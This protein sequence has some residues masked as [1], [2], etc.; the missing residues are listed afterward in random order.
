VLIII[1]INLLKYGV[2]LKKLLQLQSSNNVDT[3]SKVDTVCGYSQ[4]RSVVTINYGQKKK[5]K[6]KTRCV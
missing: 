4:G 6:Q 1:L 3:H 5:K 2:Y